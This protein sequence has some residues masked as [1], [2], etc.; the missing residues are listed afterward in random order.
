MGIL[1]EILAGIGRVERAIAAQTL[2]LDQILAWTDPP[3]VPTSLR[4]GIP[5]FVN[6]LTGEVLM[7]GP[8]GATNDHDLELDLLWADD[9]GPVAP[10]PGGTTV[11]SRHANGNYR[12]RRF[13][14]RRQDH[15]AH[16]YGCGRTCEYYGRQPRSRRRSPGSVDH[17]PGQCRRADPPDA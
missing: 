9:I 11:T 4:V 6:K 16:R 10:L 13:I 7:P 3:R 15:P 12:R 2:K 5:R 17:L 8:Y 1:T 14:Q